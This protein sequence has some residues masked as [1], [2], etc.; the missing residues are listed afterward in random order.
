M[1][2]TLFAAVLLVCAP[3]FATGPERGDGASAV[4]GASAFSSALSVS[5][6]A[7]VGIGGSAAAL[8]GSASALGGT[9]V[10]TGGTVSGLG[11]TGGA[12]SVSIAG[13]ANRAYALGMSA[14][15]ASANAC[16]ASVSLAF[17]A[18]TYSVDFCKIV[19]LAAAA[20]AAQFDS[21]SVQ[22]VLCKVPEIAESAS[23]CAG[24]AGVK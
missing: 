20:Q 15:A 11:G 22:N 24:L 9:S 6:A 14:L 3:A 7:A 10:A 18:F 4:A 16:Q 13:D 2:K 1:K 8:G 17:V 21:R 5:K 19:A 23:E 12:S